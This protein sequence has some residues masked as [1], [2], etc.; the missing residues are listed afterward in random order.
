ME[1]VRIVASDRNTCDCCKCLISRPLLGKLLQ[2]SVHYVCSRLLYHS[3]PPSHT[4]HTHTLLY[5][6]SVHTHTHTHTHCIE[7]TAAVSS[8]TVGDDITGGGLS[9]CGVDPEKLSVSSLMHRK[10][11]YVT[12][13]EQ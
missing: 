11:V 8:G 4:T 12:V 13:N 5:C 6:A 7:P 10:Q 3:L 9:L 1:F 2:I